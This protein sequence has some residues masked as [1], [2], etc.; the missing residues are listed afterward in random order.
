MHLLPVISNVL[1]AYPQIDVRLSQA[2]RS[3][4]LQEEHID[5][6]ICIGHLPE[7][8]LRAWLVGHVRWVC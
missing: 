1:K 3:V 5:A 7:S 6:A 8:G 2:D 4:S